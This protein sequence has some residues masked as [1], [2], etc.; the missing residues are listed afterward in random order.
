MDVALLLNTDTQNTCRSLRIGYTL[1]IVCCVGI[2]AYGV[3]FLRLFVTG[4]API[5]PIH[6]GVDEMAVK[7]S[8]VAGGVAVG[9]AGGST[10]TTGTG[11]VRV[12]TVKVHATHPANNSA[13]LSPLN[14]NSLAGVLSTGNKY[15]LP[16]SSDPFPDGTTAP[17]AGM[18][19]LAF[20]MLNPASYVPR[21][22]VR[23]APIEHFQSEV[24]TESAASSAAGGD[25][26]SAP[27]PAP[28]AS[29]PPTAAT[30]TASLDQTNTTP[31]YPIAALQQLTI[32]SGGGGGGGGGSGGTF[33]AAANTTGSSL[34]TGS[35]SGPATQTLSPLSGDDSMH[36]TSGSL[37]L[38]PTALLTQTPTADPS[39]PSLPAPA[40]APAAPQPRSGG[41]I[42]FSPPPSGVGGGIAIA[43]GPG[44]S[45]SPQFGPTF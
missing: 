15:A 39:H 17:G 1:W 5:I 29:H 45:A 10:I 21:Q 13:P 30:A 37:T 3:G 4:S 32:S 33:A 28:T 8:A 19:S 26:Q 44:G 36:R 11:G 18:A 43:A 7:S 16:V 41:A 12:L 27:Q 9:G 24:D 35:G 14:N 31:H 42:T 34:S 22:K 20:G 6:T 38:P 23:S 25:A 2:T 40:P